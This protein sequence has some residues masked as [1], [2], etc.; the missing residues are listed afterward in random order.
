MKLIGIVLFGCSAGAQVAEMPRV[1]VDLFM[2]S[3]ADVATIEQGIAA[4][5]DHGTVT[6]RSAPF[7]GYI[8]RQLIVIDRPMSVVFE[9]HPLSPP[10]QLNFDGGFRV[11]GTSVGDNVLIAGARAARHCFGVS[12]LVIED[13]AGKVV[14][15]QCTFAGAACPFAQMSIKR[16]A[17]VHFVDCWLAPGADPIPMEQA[18]VVLEDCLILSNFSM[19]GLPYAPV[20]AGAGAD[21]TLLESLIVGD[22]IGQVP[23]I[24]EGG[25]VRVDA[26]SGLYAEPTVGWLASGPFRG[27]PTSGTIWADPGAVLQAGLSAPTVGQGITLMQAPV[28]TVRATPAVAGGTYAVTLRGDPIDQFAAIVASPM[29][30]Q[31]FPSI[32]PSIGAG[33]DPDYPLAW[34]DPTTSQVLFLGA[35]NATQTFSVGPV[36]YWSGQILQGVFFGGDNVVRLTPPVTQV[37]A[38]PDPEVGG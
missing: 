29:D 34:M 38:D 27:V 9:P 37:F 13:C 36:P 32:H 15:E 30:T 23:L 25:I 3:G 24:M 26:L 31:P 10:G 19:F 22:Q 12:G 4:V 18:N 6:I 17:N 16:S 5:A 11:V 21:I 8:P 2:R 20:R 1:V 14:I 7:T 28:R 35:P 33:N